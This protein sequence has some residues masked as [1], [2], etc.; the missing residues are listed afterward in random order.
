MIEEGLSLQTVGFAA[1]SFDPVA[2][3]RFFEVTAGCAE[4]GL[5]GGIRPTHLQI[6]DPERKKGEAFPF[7]ENPF[8]PLAALEFLLFLPGKLPADNL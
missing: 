7:P 1:E 5:Q 2:V 6:K 3:H 4:S 8:D